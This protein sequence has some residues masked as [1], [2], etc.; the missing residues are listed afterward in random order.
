M[1][2]LT[3]LGE[4]GGITGMMLAVLMFVVRMI[5]KNGC[6]VKCYNCNGQ[7][8]AEVDIEDAATRDA[9]QSDG[10]DPTEPGV[11]PIGTN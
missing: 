7:P 11:A 5:K 9:P 3:T 6:S 10:G 4:V 2:L 1:E 8:L